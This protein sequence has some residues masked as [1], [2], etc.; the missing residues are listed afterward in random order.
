[1][2]SPAGNEIRA[3][4]STGKRAVAGMEATTWTTGCKRRDQRGESPI[5]T[6]A[7]TVQATPISKAAS[8]RNHV[9]K[10]ASIKEPHVAS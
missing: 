2:L 8:V 3:S 5:A 7:G 10:A 6:P 9:T 4:N 1:M